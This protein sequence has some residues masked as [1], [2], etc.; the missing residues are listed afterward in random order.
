MYISERIL[1]LISYGM[2]GGAE[3]ATT[4]VE[5]VSGHTARNAERSRPRYRYV[6]PYD[7]VEPAYFRALQNC[8]NACQ[9]RAHSFRFKDW[10]DYKLEDETIGTA[11]GGV[12]ETMQIVKPYTFGPVGFEETTDRPI[13]KPVDSTRFNK[14]NG[15]VEDAVALSVTEDS[16]GGPSPLSFTVDYETG[17]LTFT[18]TVGNIIRVTGEFDVP[19]HF[20]SDYLPFTFTNFQAHSTDV[21]VRE[22]FGA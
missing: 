5:L 4:E 8:F 12:D 3:W 11:V 6:A 2:E 18:S 14:A 13:T 19:V 21:E 17:I 22:D 10:A 9:G 7:S 16:G 15:Y 20:T 1:E